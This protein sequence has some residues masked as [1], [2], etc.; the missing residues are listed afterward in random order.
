M[1]SL[2]IQLYDYKV[3]MGTRLQLQILQIYPDPPSFSYDKKSGFRDC[4]WD[5]LTSGILASV[6][7]GCSEEEALGGT[8]DIPES[9]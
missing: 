6:G 5:R 8:N 7:A 3:T 2:Q 9:D 4:R 1:H